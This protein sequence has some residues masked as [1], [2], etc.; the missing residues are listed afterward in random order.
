MQEIGSR[1]ETKERHSIASKKMWA[2]GD[3]DTDSWREKQSKAHKAA[4]ARGC[5]NN[6][7]TEEYRARQSMVKK[8][9]W[10]RGDMD[11]VFRNNRPS[12][13]ERAFVD[14]FEAL[15]IVC[16][17]EYRIDG[18]AKFFDLHLPKYGLL[19]ELDGEYF[20]YSEWAVSHGIPENDAR[21]DSL[22]AKCGFPLMRI[23]GRSVKKHGS[24]TIVREIVN[25]ME[26]FV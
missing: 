26:A 10:A 11:G 24:D 3:C 21:K 15:G 13:L 20:H 22:A 8:E 23:R 1:P 25:M 6:R 5:F 12:G 17:Q 4:W 18:T 19:I 14:S 2:R 7:D 9:A 16:E